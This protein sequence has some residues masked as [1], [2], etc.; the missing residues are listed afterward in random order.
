MLRFG[1][2]NFQN[3][4]SFLSKQGEQKHTPQLN[5]VILL[6]FIRIQRKLQ[7]LNLA[8]AVTEPM[9]ITLLYPIV[10]SL[11][12][13][14]GL[15]FLATEIHRVAQKRPTII[16]AT[17]QQEGK[18]GKGTAREVAFVTIMSIFFFLY[19]GL[20][21]TMATYLPTFSVKSGLHSTKAEGA[22]VSSVF[23]GA[24]TI[25]RFITIFLSIYVN[26]LYTMII[27][28]AFSSFGAFML[29][30]LSQYSLVTLQV[31]NTVRVH[32]WEMMKYAYIALNC[33]CF[34]PAWGLAC[35]LCFQ[36]VSCG[37]KST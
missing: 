25:G 20:E 36:L 10:G 30:F 15:S 18:G 4:P 21:Q 33:R 24:F 27:C 1:E 26:P 8:T 34:L 35:L 13:A 16:E 11:A 14:C 37:L 19:M 28:F 3:Y 22:Y 9:G 32:L 17:R 29:L 23:L 5:A 12:S 7:F 2:F 31:S 6:N